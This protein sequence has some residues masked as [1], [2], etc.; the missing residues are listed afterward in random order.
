MTEHPHDPTTALRACLLARDLD[1]ACPERN[2]RIA[3]AKGLDESGCLVDQRAQA[4]PEFVEGL[5]ALTC[6]PCLHFGR[7]H[8]WVS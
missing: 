3:E 1:Q 7:S 4:C 2:R 8:K 5:A 6:Q